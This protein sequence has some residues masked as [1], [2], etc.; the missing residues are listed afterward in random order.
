MPNVNTIIVNNAQNF[1]LSELHQLRGRVGRS[2][3]KAFCYL[4]VPPAL[5]LSP[6]A[7]RRLQAI[8]SFSDL[9]S[10]IHI[11]MQD[12]TS[13]GG[14]PPR[15][16][17]ERI[18][19]RPRLRDIPQDPQGVGNRTQD[20][21]VRRRFR[22]GGSRLSSRAGGGVHSRLH[23]GERPG[24]APAGRPTCRRKANEYRS[25]RRSTTWSCPNR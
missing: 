5:P 20:R 17:T 23:G 18:H 22:R 8:E 25:T 12:S 14:Q 2:S 10:G 7:R 6:V 15:R 1:G 11:A 13:G 16:R 19:R 4:L 3:R 21:G 9:G 24:A